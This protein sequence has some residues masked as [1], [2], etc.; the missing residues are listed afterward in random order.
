LTILGRFRLGGRDVGEDSLEFS[1][2][3]NIVSSGRWA[4]SLGFEGSGPIAPSW[5]RSAESPAIAVTSLFFPG[6]SMGDLIFLGGARVALWDCSA[7]EALRFRFVAIDLSLYGLTTNHNVWPMD[8][9]L[10]ASVSCTLLAHS[11]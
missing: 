5:F 7:P 11:N 2:A 3:A 9:E 4:P 1:G 10:Y 8:H 6:R